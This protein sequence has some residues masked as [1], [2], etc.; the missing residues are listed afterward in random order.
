MST[1]VEKVILDARALLD[2]Y[3]DDGVVISE[4]DVADITAKGI[5]FV[6]MAQKELFRTGNIYKTKKIFQKPL[7]NQLGLLSNFN[8]VEHFETDQYYPPTGGV[9]AK[10]IS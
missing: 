2:E 9:V 8:I 5:R 6:D 4:Q 10:Q 7:I 1:T 3:T